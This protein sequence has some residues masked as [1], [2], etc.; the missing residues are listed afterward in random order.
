VCQSELFESQGPLVTE[1]QHKVEREEVEAW[2]LFGPAKSDKKKEVASKAT[3]FLIMT[4]NLPKS[5]IA[6]ERPDCVKECY[7]ILGS[8]LLLL[9]HLRML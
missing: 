7:R 8:C 4:S 1:L 5:I 9:L 2:L 3:S 6:D